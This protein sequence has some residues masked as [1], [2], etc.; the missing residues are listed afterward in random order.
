[1][2]RAAGPFDV[3]MTPV[4][5]DAPADG[6]PLARFSLEKRYQ[7]DLEATATGEMLSAGSPASG[8]AG[9]V[10]VERVSGTLHGRRGTFALVH[11]GLMTR[12]TPELLVTVVPGTGTG[13]LTGIAGTLTI[14]AEAG[15]HSYV[16]EYELE[17]A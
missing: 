1:M 13:E 15:R 6:A 8:S 3:K 7:G 16:L 10:A 17:P 14:L 5:S 2:S 4:A 12:G 11:R 9:Y